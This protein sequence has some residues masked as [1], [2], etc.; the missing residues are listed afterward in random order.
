MGLVGMAF[1]LGFTVGP[2]FGGELT[3]A[4]IQAPGYAAAALSLSAAE[5]GYFM[6]PEPRRHS[7]VASRVFG[8]S[9]VRRAF[10]DGRVGMVLVLG[11]LA[12]FAFSSFESMFLVFGLAKFPSYFGLDVAVEHASASQIQAAGKY[13]GRYLFI[14][15]M[16]SALI[17]GGLIRRLVPRFGETRLIIAGPLILALGLYIIAFAPTWTVVILGCVV[18]PMGFGVNNPSLNS[19]VSRASPA[20]EQGAFL[21]INQSLAS[22]ARV[23]GPMCASALFQFLG[24]R[25]PFAFAASVLV[26]AGWI[27]RTYHAR[28]AST[29]AGVPGSVS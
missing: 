25:A 22:L 9:D 12:I 16:I 2:L 19:L 29:F 27:A 10:R 7:Q 8:S 17:Q 6:L 1:G 13:A 14:V 11:F 5:F 23:A 28:Y 20:D 4:S 3:G 18:M 15:G 26:L 24:A 21:G